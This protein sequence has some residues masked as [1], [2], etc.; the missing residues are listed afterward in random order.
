MGGGGGVLLNYIY[1]TEWSALHGAADPP[2]SSQAL[3]SAAAALGP[4]CA[5]Q[6]FPQCTGRDD[7]MKVLVKC[8]IIH[9]FLFFPFP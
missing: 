2:Y 3:T 8:F 1:S 6:H 4:L 7:S 5:S 9:L